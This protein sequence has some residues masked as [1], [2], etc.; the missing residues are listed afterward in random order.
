[1]SEKT[2]KEV[3]AF[4]R[5]R[6]EQWLLDQHIRHDVVQASLAARGHDPAGALESA[7]QL[8]SAA[9]DDAF[10]VTLTAYSRS[11]RITRGKNLPDEVNPALFE[12]EQEHQLW[13]VY[14]QA[15]NALDHDSDFNALLIQLAVLRAPI[16][17]FF[18][19]VFVMAKDEAI[20]TNRLA[21]CKRVASLTD[22]IVDLSE[23]QGF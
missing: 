10:Q 7:Q 4:I 14:N 15:N 20:K 18:D 6:L 16:D 12:H 17:E 5:R 22:G 2:K 8:H 19:N 21:L 11:A 3:L 1:M 23:V 9:D 13:D